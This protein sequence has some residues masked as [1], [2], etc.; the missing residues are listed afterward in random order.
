[1]EI[2]NLN[3]IN[4]SP[5]IWEK[6]TNTFQSFLNNRLIVSVSK[7]IH[8]LPLDSIVYLSAESNYCNITMSDGKSI[9]SSK[10]LKFYETLLIDKGFLRVHSGFLI[11]LNRVSKICKK[12]G[13]NIQMDTGKIIPVSLSYKNNLFKFSS[14]NSLCEKTH[15]IKN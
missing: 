10:T 14:I 4:N 1:M 13:F 2:A 8:L 6:R 5:D 9:L 3:Q 7:S 11:N 12:N 15:Q